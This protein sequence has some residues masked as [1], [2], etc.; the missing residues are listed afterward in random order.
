MVIRAANGG[1]GPRFGL[2]VSRKVGNAVIRNRVKRWLRE[3]I[4]RSADGIGAHDVV[5]IA[6]PAAAAAGLEALASELA[7][8]LAPARR[9]PA[10]APAGAR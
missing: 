3:A 8:A 10:A 5:V 2:A 1:T 6:R 4:R 9:A 7:Q